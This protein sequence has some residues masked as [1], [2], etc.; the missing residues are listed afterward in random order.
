MLRLDKVHTIHKTI[1]DIGTEFIHNKIYE[2][3][4][5]RCLGERIDGKD[6]GIQLRRPGPFVYLVT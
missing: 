1:L 2:L 4:P 3:I 5:A 6:P